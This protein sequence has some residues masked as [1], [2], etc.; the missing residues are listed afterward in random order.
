MV[1]QKFEN[2]LKRYF[3]EIKSLFPVYGE[4]EKQFLANL[5]SDIDKFTESNP[6]SDY[7][8]LI[9]SF[10]E[11]KTIVSQYIADADSAYLAKQIKTT[12]FVRIGVIAIIITS[13]IAVASVVAVK[14]MDYVKGQ[15][16]YIDREIVEM[17]EV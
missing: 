13:V 11:P 1:Q 14:Y 10:G 9:S 5:M 12:K 16:Y 4:K 8:Q 6:V 2:D 7:M 3:K 15:A 17:G